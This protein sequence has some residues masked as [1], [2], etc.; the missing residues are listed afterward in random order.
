MKHWF[1]GSRSIAYSVVM[2]SWEELVSITNV[3]GEESGV[4]VVC[5][6][7]PDGSIAAD[8]ISHFGKIDA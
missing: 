2:P 6:G 5:E 3:I 1:G 7:G 8:G 4:F